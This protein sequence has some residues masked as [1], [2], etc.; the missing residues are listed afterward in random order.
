M[1]LGI[2]NCF[3]LHTLQSVFGT[4]KIATIKIGVKVEKTNILAQNVKIAEHGHYTAV[5]WS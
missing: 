1:C 5:N 2:K 4:S 3:C